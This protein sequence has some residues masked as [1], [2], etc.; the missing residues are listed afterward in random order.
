MS[1][2]PSDRGTDRSW[3][4]DDTP[5]SATERRGDEFEWAAVTADERSSRQPE[6][7]DSSTVAQ[8]TDDEAGLEPRSTPIESEGTTL[9]HAVM[10]ALGS[11]VTILVIWHLVALLPV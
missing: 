1:D 2:D 8:K 11:L 7:P 9:E 6:P 10:V 3:S 4:P 5:L